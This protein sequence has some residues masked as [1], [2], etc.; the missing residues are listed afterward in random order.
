MKIEFNGERYDFE[1]TV[2]QEDDDFTFEIEAVHKQTQ[3]KSTINQVNE[4][5]SYFFRDEDDIEYP[6]DAPWTIKERDSIL[7]MNRVAELM[8]EDLSWLEHACDEDRKAGEWSRF[9]KILVQFD[10]DAL[11]VTDEYTAPVCYHH[12]KEFNMM[13]TD[14]V[15]DYPF[16]YCSVLGCM[17][18]ADV[19][20]PIPQ[21]KIDYEIVNIPDRPKDKSFQWEGFDVTVTWDT[22]KFDPD[23]AEAVYE[24]QNYVMQDLENEPVWIEEICKCTI[25]Y[26]KKEYI[27]TWIWNNIPVYYTDT[28]Y[29]SVLLFEETKAKALHNYGYVLNKKEGGE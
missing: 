1:V 16:L 25:S 5:L 23:D 29:I 14:N 27:Y 10:A 22:E 28:D 15:E 26:T 20:A 9:N 6:E 2:N 21:A 4:V 3:L 19:V 7:Y 24:L 11:I 12:L 8:V 17:H 13:F 18:R